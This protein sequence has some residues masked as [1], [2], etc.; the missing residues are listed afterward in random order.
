MEFFY[1]S[2]YLIVLG[3]FLLMLLI[4]FLLTKEPTT[5]MKSLFPRLPVLLLFF[6]PVFLVE[7]TFATL[8]EAHQWIIIVLVAPIIEELA[9]F[10]IT[11]F[12][13]LKKTD[14]GFLIGILI[15]TIETAV[16]LKN[17]GL[18]TGELVFRLFF[19]QPLHATQGACLLTT[20]K[21]LRVNILVHFTFNYGLFVGG[22]P[23][24]ILVVLSLL[25]NIIR[26]IHFNSSSNS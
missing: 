20:F 26:I 21:P 19:T 12:L 4:W 16:L 10:F 11:D 25:A 6:L 23:G 17:I 9:R 8:L 7:K 2:S 14:E 24:S 3:S 5:C 22:I 1:E 18:N 15:G 13:E